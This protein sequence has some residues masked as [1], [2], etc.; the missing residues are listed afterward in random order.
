MK[1]LPSFVR[2]L[3]R[4]CYANGGQ[5]KRLCS[6]KVALVICVFLAPICHHGKRSENYVFS[7][8]WCWGTVGLFGVGSPV[9]ESCGNVSCF[10]SM[11]YLSECFSESN[12]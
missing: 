11:F 10:D 2:A 7:A 4:Q 1:K 8:K 6:R 3:Y 12:A 5:R 9:K